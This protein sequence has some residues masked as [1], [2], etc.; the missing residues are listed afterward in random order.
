M[1]LFEDERVNRME[2]S[3]ELFEEV[4]NRYII[5]KFYN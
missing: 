2:E 1:K 3:L 5:K 4:A